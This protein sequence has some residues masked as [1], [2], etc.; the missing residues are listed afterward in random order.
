M[1][2][3]SCA[4][5]AAPPASANAVRLRGLWP[6]ASGLRRAERGHER[7]QGP[8][9]AAVAD[10]QSLAV[11]FICES[12]AYRKADKVANLGRGADRD[13]DEVQVVAFPIAGH[14]PRRD[15]PAPRQHRGGSGSEDRIAPR[16]G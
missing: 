15:S 12:E 4:R 2:A 1:S 10:L 7:L 11:G 13:A 5:P 16:R 9:D 14:S 6:R 8:D 3:T